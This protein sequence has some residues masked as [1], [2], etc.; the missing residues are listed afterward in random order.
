MSGGFNLQKLIIIALGYFGLGHLSLLMAVPPG[1]ASPVFPAAGFAIAMML[2]YGRQML[3]GIFLGSLLL[4]FNVVFQSNNSFSTLASVAHPIIIALG[5]SLQFL[6]LRVHQIIIQIPS[7][8][9]L[10]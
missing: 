3:L 5:S 7:G 8:M 2:I 1:F 6:I 4:N 10:H 9:V